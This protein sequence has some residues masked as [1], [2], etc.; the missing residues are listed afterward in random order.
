MAT[1]HVGQSA[2][3]SNQPRLLPVMAAVLLWLAVIGS[4][5][6]VVYSTHQSRQL[7]NQ[8]AKE[9]A[10]SAELAEQWGQYLLERSAWGAYNRVEALASD[11]LQMSP[12]EAEHIVVVER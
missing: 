11:Q 9:Q 12:P 2:I 1:K 6:G 10:K 4:A 3:P 5:L 8:L 7:T